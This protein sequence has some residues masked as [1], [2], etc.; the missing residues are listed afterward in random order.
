M[1]GARQPKASHVH[2]YTPEVST[3]LRPRHGLETPNCGGSEIAEAGL[4]KGQGRY[5]G[6]VRSEDARAE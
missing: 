5:G 4:H 1:R 6:G 2:V 3:V